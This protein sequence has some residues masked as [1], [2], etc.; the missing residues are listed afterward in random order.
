M[1]LTPPSMAVF[2]ISLLLVAAAVASVQGLIHGL[3]F[4][5]FWIAIAGYVVLAIGNLFKGV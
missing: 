4:S 5:A 2:V 3:P 1:R